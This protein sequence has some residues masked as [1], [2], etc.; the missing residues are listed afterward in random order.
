MTLP[1]VRRLVASHT[2]TGEPYVQDS[3][4]TIHPLP[5]GLLAGYPFIQL[6]LVNVDPLTQV[7]NADLKP[8]GFV[9]SGGL[10]VKVIDI[11]AGKRT[12]MHYTHTIG[13]YE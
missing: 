8:D 5:N 6:G 4:V 12:A 13:G 3:Q 2:S 9:Q 1:P 7:G 10:T 11:P